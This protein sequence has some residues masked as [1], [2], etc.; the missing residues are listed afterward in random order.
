M[1]SSINREAARESW[2]ARGEEESNAD[3]SWS[4]ASLKTLQR[5]FHTYRF[6]NLRKRRERERKREVHLFQT[7]E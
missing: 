3:F 6:F 7:H 5:E 4:R 1:N 2:E